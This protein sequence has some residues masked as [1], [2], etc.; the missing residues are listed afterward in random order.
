MTTSSDG[1]ACLAEMPAWSNPSSPPGLEDLLVAEV[2][3]ELMF[4]ASDAAY[5]SG[6]I[7]K[8]Q[9]LVEGWSEFITLWETVLG[10]LGRAR[11]QYYQLVGHLSYDVGLP[12]EALRGYEKALEYAPTPY[13]SAFL[14]ISMARVER[15]LGLTEKSW[16]HAVDAIEAWL[17]SPYPQ[18][19]DT[20]IEWLS[21]DADSSDRKAVIGQL[22]RRK[23]A[24]GG[25][26]TNRVARAMTS[27]Y[28]LL[29]DLHAGASPVQ[30]AP[31]LDPIIAE[32]EK[33][34]SWPNMVTLLATRAVIAGRMGERDKMD[35]AIG[36]ARNLISSKLAPDARPPAEF[37]VESAH[38][39]ALRDVGAYDEAFHTLFERALE[40]RAKYPGGVGP[41]ERTAFEAVYYL[42]ALAGHD[43]ATIERRVKEVLARSG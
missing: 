13:R 7:R 33:A 10:P 43:P 4:L 5:R 2:G 3:H 21:L 24:A 1:L 32:L 37:F 25:L 38:A 26:E 40:A 9:E 20:W 19:A 28:R 30:L 8:A 42:G 23:E 34:G 11:Y 14:W 18:T 12:E 17:E 31:L 27:L 35:K 22:R 29:G 6:D 16:R 36:D 41:E 15:E 39:L